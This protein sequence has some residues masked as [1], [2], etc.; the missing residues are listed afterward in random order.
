[1]PQLFR[2]LHVLELG[3]GVGISGLAIARCCSP[4]RCLLTDYS[5]AALRSMHHNTALLPA[6]AA[7]AVSVQHLDWAALTPAAA[8][9]LQPLDCIVGA[10]VMYDPE[11]VPALARTLALLMAPAPPAAC[12]G[13]GAA[14]AAGDED[15]SA[16]FPPG[17]LRPGARPLVLLAYVPRDPR[18]RAVFRGA[19]RSVGLGAV[20]VT[21]ASLA[22]VELAGGALVLQLS[23]GDGR[24]G[25]V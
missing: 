15:L 2:G 17:E 11:A 16:P 8:A 4:A 5:D 3:A 23:A 24:A 14:A 1:M 21:A 7:A 12:G 19:L 22:G 25:G 9:A 13:D 20:D 18:T 6:R 10:D